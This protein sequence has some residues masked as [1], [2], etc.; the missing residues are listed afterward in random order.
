MMTKTFKSDPVAQEYK[1][2]LEIL[3]NQKVTMVTGLRRVSWRVPSR[4][5]NPDR[6][7]Y[8]LV[9]LKDPLMLALSMRS[10]CKWN[11]ANQNREICQNKRDF[12]HKKI[13]EFFLM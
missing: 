11:F 2:V 9:F 6:P 8:L 3:Y 10:H 12:T 13:Q 5:R 4:K 7:D 1:I